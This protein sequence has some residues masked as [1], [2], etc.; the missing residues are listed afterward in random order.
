MRKERE[1]EYK[2]GREQRKKENPGLGEK[3]KRERHKQEEREKSLW[4]PPHAWT[5]DYEESIVFQFLEERIPGVGSNTELSVI[6]A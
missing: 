5:P 4:P 1:R 6:Q 2:K 3:P